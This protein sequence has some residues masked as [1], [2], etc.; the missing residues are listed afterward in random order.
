MKR[1]PDL[2]R[3]GLDVSAAGAGNL[4]SRH[5]G[6]NDGPSVRRDTPHGL[7]QDNFGG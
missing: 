1:A 3:P 7:I 6:M 4:K 5:F 2:R